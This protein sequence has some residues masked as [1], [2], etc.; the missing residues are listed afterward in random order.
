MC[1]QK[2]KD[3]KKVLT[4]SYIEVAQM[5]SPNANYLTYFVRYILGFTFKPSTM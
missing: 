1:Q 3:R 5:E 2:Q 4:L